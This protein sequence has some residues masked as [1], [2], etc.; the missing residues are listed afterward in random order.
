MYIDHDLYTLCQQ[1]LQI[2]MMPPSGLAAI[3]E[4]LFLQASISHK[5]P[6]TT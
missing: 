5:S 2:S 3:L 4:A 1:S 6:N